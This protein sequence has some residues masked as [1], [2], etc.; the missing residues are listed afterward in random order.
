LFGEK[1]HGDTKVGRCDRGGLKDK[2]SGIGWMCWRD[3]PWQEQVRS[4][5]TELS[6]A[7]DVEFMKWLGE[8]GMHGIVNAVWLGLFFFHTSEKGLNSL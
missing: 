7:T 1:V 8:L 6:V 4:E 5:Y 2:L 3:K